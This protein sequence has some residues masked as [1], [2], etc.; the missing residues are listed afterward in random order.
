M[1]IISSAVL[2]LIAIASLTACEG[3]GKG[4]S[5]PAASAATSE[6]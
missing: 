4:P 3:G 6:K 5:K 2:L 1:K